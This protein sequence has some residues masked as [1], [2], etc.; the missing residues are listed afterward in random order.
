MLFAD[1]RNRNLTEVVLAK[2]R[3]SFWQHAVCTLRYISGRPLPLLKSLQRRLLKDTEFVPR[4]T[5]AI[6]EISVR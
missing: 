2:L 4:C 1:L 6:L 5:N 3:P